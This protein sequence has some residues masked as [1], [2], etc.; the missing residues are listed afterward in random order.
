VKGLQLS[1][2]D[3]VMLALEHAGRGS[4]EMPMIMAVGVG[5]PSRDELDYSRDPVNVSD[6]HRIVDRVIELWAASQTLP[7]ETV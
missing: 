7:V 4:A 1:G 6:R 2:F 5:R 3:Y